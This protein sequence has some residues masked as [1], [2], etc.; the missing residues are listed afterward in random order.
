MYLMFFFCKLIYRFKFTLD[1]SLVSGHN[2]VLVPY[3]L[4]EPLLLYNVS[5]VR[6][7]CVSVVVISSLSSEFFR[8]PFV[9]EL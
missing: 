2:K 1:L 4:S 3:F 8:I 6:S 5:L 7:T 9:Q